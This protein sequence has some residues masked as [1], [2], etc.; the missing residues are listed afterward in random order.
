[1]K[2]TDIIEDEDSLRESS[3]T[4][5]ND[6]SDHFDNCWFLSMAFSS[7]LYKNIRKK[8]QEVS[9]DKARNV[10]VEIILMSVI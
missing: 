2:P 8:R 10:V 5:F 3:T 9:D 1:M 7:L 4:C 6:Y